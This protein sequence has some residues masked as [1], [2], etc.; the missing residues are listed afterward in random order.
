MF[1]RQV[2]RNERSGGLKHWDIQEQLGP[3]SRET[4]NYP[5]VNNMYYEVIVMVK[6]NGHR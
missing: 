2:E 3:G 5:S 4:K 1:K 6:N